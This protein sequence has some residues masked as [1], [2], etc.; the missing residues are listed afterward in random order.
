TLADWAGHAFYHVD[1]GGIGEGS[2][3]PIDEEIRRQV[4][5]AMVEDDRL[6]LVVDARVWENPIELVIVELLRIVRKPWLLVDNKV[7]DPD[8]ADF[9]EFYSLGAGQPI[10]VSAANGEQSGE[11]L[12]AIVAAIPD[13][14]TEDL[15][16]ALRV[17]VVGRPNVGKSSFINR[18]LGEER[19]VV[20]ETAGTT[21]DAIDTPL[22]YHGRDFIFV[23]TAGLRRQ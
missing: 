20:S 15:T 10:P 7:D 2:P 19:L 12:D 11:L 16:P 23:D 5:L 6:L 3:R 4:Q 9:Y 17:A 1:N 21:R 8:S 14:D 22:R 18:L 13:V